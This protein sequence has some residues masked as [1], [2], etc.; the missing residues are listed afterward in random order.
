MPARLYVYYGNQPLVLFGRYPLWWIPGLITG[1]FFAAAFAAHYKEQLKGWKAFF[2]LLGVP[3]LVAGGYAV[4]YLPGWVAVNGSYPW[5]VTQALGLSCFGIAFGFM[6]FIIDVLLDRNP[7]DLNSLG[8]RHS[9]QA[10][11]IDKG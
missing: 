3:L 4:V 8:P 1:I 9:N 2:M 7:F 5:L 10:G 6:C 11:L